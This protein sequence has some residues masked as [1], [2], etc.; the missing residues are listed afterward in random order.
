MSV[1]RCENVHNSLVLNDT[2]LDSNVGSIGLPHIAAGLFEIVHTED[3]TNV[4]AYFQ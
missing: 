4:V 2:M 1:C 3:K